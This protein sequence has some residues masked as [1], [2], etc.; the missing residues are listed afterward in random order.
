MSVSA[1]QPHPELACS[2]ESDGASSGK[3]TGNRKLLGKTILKL[4]FL[5]AVLPP[6]EEDR[7]LVVS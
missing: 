1:M 2:S 3:G 4:Q 6:M 5:H 7:K